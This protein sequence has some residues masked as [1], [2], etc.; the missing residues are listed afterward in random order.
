MEGKDDVAGSN[1][2]PA[3]RALGKRRDISSIRRL[4]GLNKQLRCPYMIPESYQG[5]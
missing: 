3:G 2:G 4:P 5:S 1:G